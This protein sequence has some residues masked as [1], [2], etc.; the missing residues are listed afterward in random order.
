MPGAPVLRSYEGSLAFSDADGG[1]VLSGSDFAGDV[2]VGEEKPDADA[3]VPAKNASLDSENSIR[4]SD[5]VPS[6]RITADQADSSQ[7][8]NRSDLDYSPHCDK[9]CQT[10]K[11][12]YLKSIQDHATREGQKYLCIFARSPYV[13]GKG[14]SGGASCEAASRTNRAKLAAEALVYCKKGADRRKLPEFATRC[15]VVGS[16]VITPINNPALA[17][18]LSLN[19]MG[20]QCKNGLKSWQAKRGHKAFAVSTGGSCGFN[21]GNSSKKNSINEALRLCKRVARGEKCWIHR[22]E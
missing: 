12:I 19:R 15:K 14:Q 11:G 4:S 9:L 7:Q 1:L 6:S 17:H 21:S 2:I 10:R 22:S 5:R 8:R 20:V 13:D 16:D 18:Q 3:G